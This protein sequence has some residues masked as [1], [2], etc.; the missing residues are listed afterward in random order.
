[1]KCLAAAGRLVTRDKPTWQTGNGHIEIT[2]LISAGER[3]A[4]RARL[5]VAAT[6]TNALLLG[7]MRYPAI[8]SFVTINICDNRLHSRHH[9]K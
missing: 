6:V 9:K 2:L 4:G 3:R 1:M 5:C 8:C 7:Y